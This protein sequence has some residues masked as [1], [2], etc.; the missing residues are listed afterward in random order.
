MSRNLVETL[1]LNNK[2]GQVELKIYPKAGHQIAGT[3]T[4]PIRLYG[5]QSLDKDA[6]DIAAEGEAAADAWRR[7]VRFLRN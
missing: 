4:F 3:G 6:K 5:E 7:T 2:S 1:A